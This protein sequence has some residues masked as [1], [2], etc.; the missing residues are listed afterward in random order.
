MP[1]LWPVPAFIEP[2]LLNPDVAI[3]TLGLRRDRPC[4]RSEGHAKFA[5]TTIAAAMKW[6]RHPNLRERPGHASTYLVRFT[7]HSHRQRRHPESSISR[8]GSITGVEGA[9]L[10]LRR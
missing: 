6:A 8:L 3:S 5:V 10:W 7:S 9:V 2:V 1:N 4:G